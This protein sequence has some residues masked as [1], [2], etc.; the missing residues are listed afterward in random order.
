MEKTPPRICPFF[1]VPLLKITVL[2]S[3]D[4]NE[5]C[6]SFSKKSFPGFRKHASIASPLDPP[7]RRLE[8]TETL[9]P[10]P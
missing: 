8:G 10:S 1:S 4:R 6:G 9:Y 7:R 2:F 3:R 5:L